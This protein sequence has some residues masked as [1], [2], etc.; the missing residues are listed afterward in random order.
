MGIPQSKNGVLRRFLPAPF[1]KGASRGFAALHFKLQFIF[2]DFCQILSGPLY[3]FLLIVYDKGEQSR[4]PRVKCHRDGELPGGRRTIPRW[5]RRTRCCI[6]DTLLYVATI[7]GRAKG[8]LF[9]A[10]LPLGCTKT[11]LLPNRRVGAFCFLPQRKRA[12]SPPFAP[13]Q[14]E[15]FFMARHQRSTTLYPHPFSAAYWRDAAAELKDTRMLVVTALL[16]ALRIALKPFAIYIGPQMAIQTATLAT[17]LGA[18]IYGPVVAIPAAMISDTIGFMIFPTGDYFLPFMLTEIAGTM[19]YALC[20]YRAKPSATRVIIARFLICFLV[21]VVL[22]QFIFAWQYT[23]MGNPEKAKDAIMGIMTT[24]RIF[25]NLFF[26]PIETVVITLFLKVLVPV[27]SRAKLTYSTGDLTFTKKQIAAL[28]L[29][30]VVGIGSAI[31]YLNFRYAGDEKTAPTSRSADYT[32]EQ[33]VEANQNVTDIVKGQV[34]DLPEGAVVC[35]VDSAYRPLFGAETEYTVSVYVLDEEAF[36]IGQAEAAAK[37][38][39]YDMD[40]LWGYSKSG[41]G[42][43][44][45]K[46]LVKAG[47]ATFTVEESTG[48]VF[49]FWYTPVE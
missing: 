34:A 28:V 12:Q 39:T 15:A 45:Y 11:H 29:L 40:T 47:T 27:T 3:I 2:P 46:S 5:G 26:F 20:L 30:V 33:R 8:R 10:E 21:N 18:M 49:D 37:G 25:K 14:K 43:D 16:V 42:K 19:I 24:A 7:L 35:I 1:D 32:D 13:M 38:E 36:A 22:Q 17:A 31:G 9:L 41:P 6:Q 23:Y 44:Q 48:K 4:R